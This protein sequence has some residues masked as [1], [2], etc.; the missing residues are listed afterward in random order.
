MEMN[1][2]TRSLGAS[3]W[4]FVFWMKILILWKIG[5]FAWK[6]EAVH[7]RWQPLDWDFCF[8]NHFLLFLLIN[9]VQISLVF[10]KSLK[11][12]NLKID[13]VTN[14]GHYIQILIFGH[15]EPLNYFMV[16]LKI[17]FRSSFIMTLLIEVISQQVIGRNVFQMVNL[18]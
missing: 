8:F 1:N 3:I 5:S 2:K 18:F 10:M 15:F 11:F 9:V 12:S 4:L 16:L 17:S 13:F 6:I 14:R 7:S